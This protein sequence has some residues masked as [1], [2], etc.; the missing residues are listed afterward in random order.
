MDYTQAYSVKVGDQWHAAMR[1]SDLGDF[2][3]IQLTTYQAIQ[4]PKASVTAIRVYLK[5]DTF[6]GEERKFDLEVV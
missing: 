1:V 2:L 3:E 4:C 5:S 6:V